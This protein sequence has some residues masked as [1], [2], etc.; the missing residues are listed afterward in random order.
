MHDDNSQANYNTLYLLGRNAQPTIWKQVKSSSTFI[1]T[2]DGLSIPAPL[3]EWKSYRPT[4]KEGK[5][6]IKGLQKEI[7]KLK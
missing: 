2:F 4:T 1:D 5:E 7:D 6:I 3:F